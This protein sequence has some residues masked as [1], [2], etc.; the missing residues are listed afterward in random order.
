MSEQP[1]D[2][3]KSFESLV[4]DYLKSNPYIKGASYQTQKVP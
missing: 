4:D 2:P 1:I 3:S